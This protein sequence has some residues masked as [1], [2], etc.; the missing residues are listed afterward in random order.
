MKASTEYKT[1]KHGVVTIIRNPKDSGG[2]YHFVI[3]INKETYE[4]SSYNSSYINAL[5]TVDKELDN[6][7]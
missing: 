7:K 5:N 2:I 3:K 1:A 6:A 4:Y